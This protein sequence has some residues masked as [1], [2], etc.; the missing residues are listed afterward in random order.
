[1]RQGTVFFLAILIAGVATL[2]PLSIGKGAAIARITGLGVF[3]VMFPL[4]FILNIFIL[5]W[6]RQHGRD[7]QQ[8]EKYESEG[9]FITLH[10]KDAGSTL[11]D[12]KKEGKAPNIEQATLPEVE[13]AD[14]CGDLRREQFTERRFFHYERTHR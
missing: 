10:A 12:N 3:I 13:G 9:G 2:L 14:L 11:A 5:R 6:R 8:E 1:M 4:L 7:I